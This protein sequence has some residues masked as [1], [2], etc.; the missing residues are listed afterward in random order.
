[1]G[2]MIGMGLDDSRRAAEVMAEVLQTELNV[3]V[4]PEQIVNLFRK[5]WQTLSHLAHS[6]HAQ[7][8]REEKS[9]EELDHQRRQ[10]D[11]AVIFGRALSPTPPASPP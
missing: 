8:E 3:T 6:I 9:A 2:L 1:M 7:I 5:R 4:S 10:T 11:A